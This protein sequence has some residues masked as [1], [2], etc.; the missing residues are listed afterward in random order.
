M[1]NI[2]FIGCILVAMIGSG[3]LMAASPTG[4]EWQGD[5]IISLLAFDEGMVEDFLQ[6][7]MSDYAVECPTGACLPLKMIVKG[8][9]LALDSADIAPLYLKILKTCYIR[10][11]GK[12]NFL[13]STDLQKWKGFS[14]FF[15][16]ELK[17]SVN[18]QNGG[19]IAGLEL[20]LNQRKSS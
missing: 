2:R 16:G 17:A 20:E 4:K 5:R 19:P 12:D 14:E 3:Q 6:G 11:E 8:E 10:Y 18:S 13:F 9:F 15:T 7:K 1:K